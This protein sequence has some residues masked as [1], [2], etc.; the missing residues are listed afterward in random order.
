MCVRLDV[1]LNRSFEGFVP[2]KVTAWPMLSL[3]DGYC[4][5]GTPVELKERYLDSLYKV[6]VF[7]NPYSFRLWGLI[8]AISGVQQFWKKYS[9]IPL[10]FLTSNNQFSVLLVDL[11]FYWIY[12]LI[13]FRIV[14]SWKIQGT[15]QN[16]V[17]CVLYQTKSTETVAGIGYIQV[18]KIVTVR[19]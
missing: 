19:K 3:Y 10:F 1:S 17:S 12:G 16:S 18:L 8:P 9:G 4:I 5:L 14:D 7:V 11:C 13:S 2:A 15:F 6:R